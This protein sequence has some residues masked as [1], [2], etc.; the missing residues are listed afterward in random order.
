MIYMA[1]EAEEDI[2]RL[3]SAVYENS[4]NVG[5]HIPWHGIQG[6]HGLHLTSP[7]ATSFLE[8]ILHSL[9]LLFLTTLFL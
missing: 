8:H 1:V 2:R 9:P 7:P 5:L 3:T 4:Q 6:T